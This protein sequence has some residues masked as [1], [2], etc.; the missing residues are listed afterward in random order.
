VAF[1]TLTSAIEFAGSVSSG[2]LRL[3]VVFAVSSWLWLR[4]EP[5]GLDWL[6]WWCGDRFWLWRVNDFR[7]LAIF[8]GTGAETFFEPVG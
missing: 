8:A 6:S 1:A 5:G 4:N 7:V 3:N 2:P